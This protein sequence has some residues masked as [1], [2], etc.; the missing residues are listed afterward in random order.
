MCHQHVLITSLCYSMSRR[1]TK[2]GIPFEI[3]TDGKRTR[4]DTT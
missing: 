4:T 1:L 3:E 2:L